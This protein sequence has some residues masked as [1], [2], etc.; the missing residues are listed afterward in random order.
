MQ[1]NRTPKDWGH[2]IVSFKSI[3]VVAIGYGM[4][5]VAFLGMFAIGVVAAFHL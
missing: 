2:I 3:R 5:V 1:S 4:L